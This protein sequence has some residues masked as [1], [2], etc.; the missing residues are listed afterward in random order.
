MTETQT[1]AHIL[2]VILVQ[3]FGL[4]KGMEL[5]GKKE[6][7]AVVKELTQIHELETYE[8]IMASGL[9]WE[10]KKKALES[11][12][13]I[14]EKRNGDIKARKVSD[15]SKHR[16]YNRYDKADGSSPTV[17]TESIFFTG[18]VDARE[19][20]A[21][22]VLDAANAFLHAQNDERFLMLL[23]GKISEMMVRIYPSM[24]RKYVTHSKN[25]VPMLYVRLSKALYGML[26][27]ALLLYKRLRSDLEDRGFVVKPYDPCVSNNMED[28]SQMTVCWHVDDLKISHRDEEMV[29]AFTVE[30]ANIYGANT[31][32]SRGR[33][34]D[35]LG[36]ELYFRTSPCTL[37]ISMINYLQKIIDDFPEVLRGTKDFPAGDN[38]FK[39]LDD[40]NREILPEEMSRQFN[41]TTT[42]LLFL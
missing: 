38:L 40:E 7:A 12:L 36:T 8:P 18:V 30:M 42:R 5:F 1:D 24:Y 31:T 41:R 25:G 22:A 6:D 17:T 28:R 10:E 23:R 21:V 39:I 32:I 11:L 27:A 3:K 20:R 37:I 34:H 14:T 26:R 29:T 19:G 35:Y 4:K 33:V 13:F 15:D 9:S 2:G 16:T